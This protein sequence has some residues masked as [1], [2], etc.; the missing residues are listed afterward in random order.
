[1]SEFDPT[2]AALLV[3]RYRQ[4]EG[5]SEQGLFCRTKIGWVLFECMNNLGE[6]RFRSTLS[7]FCP[8]ICWEDVTRV[9]RLALVAG[10]QFWATSPSLNRLDSSTFAWLTNRWRE[11]EFLSNMGLFRRV[12]LG[13]RLLDW[14]IDAGEL[15]LRRILTESCPEI[16]WAAAQS[17]MNWALVIDR[18]FLDALC[19]PPLQG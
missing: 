13:D 1:M 17:A 8:E 9:M 10:P 5:F 16:P 12:E 18:E 19:L 6:M 4:A 3:E 11:A 15:Q 14:R 7:G 2:A